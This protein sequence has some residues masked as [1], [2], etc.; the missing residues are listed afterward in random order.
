MD[1]CRI[2]SKGYRKIFGLISPIV[3]K[4]IFFIPIKE[5]RIIIDNFGGKGFGDN[6]KYIAEAL[7]SKQ[8]ERLDIVWLVD[9][10][11]PKAMYKDFPKGI[12]VVKINS[13]AGLYARTTAKVW[14]DNVR[15]L[16]PVKKK[17]KQVYLQTWHAPFSPKCVEKDAENMLGKRYIK[18]AM[19][20]G[21][22]TT[23]ILVNS[24]LQE[25][26]FKRAFW[27]NPNTEILRFGLPRNDALIKKKNDSQ[28][29]AEIKS[30]YGITD[31]YYYILYAPTFRDDFSVK[32]YALDFE[33]I[34][35]GFSEVMKKPCKIIVRLHP[36]AAFQK[37]NICF[38]EYILDGTD[39]PDI[40][41]LSLICNAVISDYSTSIFDFA[42]LEKPAFICALDLEE[43]KSKRGLLQEFYSFPFPI[44]TTSQQLV[45]NIRDF[46]SEKYNQ[47]VNDYFEKYP[48]Y[49]DGYAAQ[50]TA[51]WI[52][53]NE[54]YKI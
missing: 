12:R 28:I 49:D 30:I 16:H 17:S 23:G 20:D 27:L 7:L 29:I 3:A 40:Q 51:N 1:I 43:Y 22:I 26:Q 4:C 25:N 35:V 19:Y 32:G 38:T 9:N 15:H 14:V 2:V 8:S 18:E 24:K 5:N 10:L 48:I 50:K 21:K 13:F 33:K 44:A 54:M 42:L 39:Y 6:P 37:T 11:M 41:E 34:R 31:A 52:L 36:N 46:D 53:K 45:Q 47:R